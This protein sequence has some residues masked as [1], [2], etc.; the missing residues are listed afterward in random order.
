[1]SELDIFQ[2]GAKS[3]QTHLT[4]ICSKLIMRTLEKESL[5]E[6]NNKN[7]RMTSDLVLVF[8]L[9]ILNIFRIFV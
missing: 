1:M 8:L 7:T 4:F 6:V 5:F 3:K 9:L 2:S